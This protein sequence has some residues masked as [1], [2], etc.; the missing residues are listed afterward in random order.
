MCN[1]SRVSRCS[2]RYVL[3]G[4][5]ALPLNGF[6]AQWAS[7]SNTGPLHVDAH[8]EELARTEFARLE[9]ASG[10][11]L[12]VAARLNGADTTLSYRGDERFP[13][14]STFKVVAA[15]AILRDKPQ[16][17]GQRIRFAKGDIKPWSPITEKHLD[18]GLTVAEL[19]A[20]MLQHSDNTATNIVLAQLGG[21]L[22][23]TAFARS[24]GDSAFRLDRWE[25]EL[26]SA[27]AG[28][29]RDTTTPLAMCST[30]QGLVCGQ[31]LPDPARK[32]LTGWMLGCATGAGRITAAAPKGWRVAHKSGGG[33][34]G[35]TND[36]G[37]L[38]PQNTAKAKAAPLVV[39]VYLTG[40]KLPET[41]ND[42]IIAS[43]AHL[44]CAAEGL[45]GPNDN[46]Y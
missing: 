25:V 4:L 39:N 41:D 35:T 9:T 30:L 17:L 24:L 34:N 43:A 20:A 36:I 18:D 6:F 11:R 44:V 29:E 14:C 12:G 38:L 5:C 32:Q 1:T 28:D 33:D 16:I 31:L 45:A 23:L 2:R 15:A 40:S 22:G 13:M 42:K 21:P 7:A 3:A 37:L 27:I 26:N 19:C 46:M 10:G 8:K